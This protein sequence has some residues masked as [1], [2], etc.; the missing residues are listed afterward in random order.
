MP[1]DIPRKSRPVATGVLL[2]Y[3]LFLAAC[4]FVTLV[5][6]PW[7]PSGLERLFGFVASLAAGLPWSLVLM[8][9]VRQCA[10]CDS[11]PGGS[12]MLTVV[13]S[14]LGALLN[15]VW[16]ASVA[17]WSQAAR[18]SP[19][20]QPAPPPMPAPGRV[21]KSQVT[22]T[23]PCG[24]R[25][26]LRVRWARAM[27]ST[28]GSFD[29]VRQYRRVTVTAVVLTV[30][31]GLPSFMGLLS[32]GQAGVAGTPAFWSVGVLAALAGSW[33]RLLSSNAQLQR[34]YLRFGT[35]LA[36]IACGTALA[37]LSVAAWLPQTPA[38]A[39][40]ALGLAACQGYLLVATMGSRRATVSAPAA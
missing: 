1:E 38:W 5:A 22:A 16:L 8:G 18:E 30:L 4:A 9:V 11:F 27:A 37:M 23:P 36:G 28:A 26:P 31:L 40:F 12:D 25:L 34:S 17:G 19:G 21:A 24:P 13:L 10:T 39:L 32:A 20:Q 33:C 15:F 35:A 2:L 6:P 29:A 7:N 3:V 14:W